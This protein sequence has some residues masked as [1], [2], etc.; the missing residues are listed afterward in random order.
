MGRL[1]AR[2]TLLDD[3]DI[4]SE[5]SGLALDLDRVDEELLESGLVEL[6]AAAKG[7]REDVRRAPSEGARRA[8]R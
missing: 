1:G 3:L 8:R 6:R 5:V 2:R 7:E 4:V